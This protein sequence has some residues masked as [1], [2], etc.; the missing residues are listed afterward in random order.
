MRMSPSH[1]TFVVHPGVEPQDMVT[2]GERAAARV[3]LGIP[4]GRT[5]VGIVAR[6]DRW[7]RQ[8]LFLQ[9]LADLGRR[10]H[11][12][13]GLLVGGDACVLPGGFPDY[14]HTLA[15]DLGLLDRVTFTGHVPNV[16]DHMRAMDV[17]VSASRC[18]PFG[19]NLLEA[20]SVGVAVVAVGTCGPAEIIESSVSGLLIGAGDDRKLLSDAVEQ[21]VRDVELRRRLANGGMR[22]VGEHFT[23]T[24]MADAFVRNLEAVLEAEAPQARVKA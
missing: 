20:M 17:L 19:I 10:G 7:K 9:V 24:A 1:Y 23:A 5:V 13:H 6:L 22:R 16:L 4:C 18:E 15:G 3:R 14:I 12:V 2:D 21:L 8:D 11:D